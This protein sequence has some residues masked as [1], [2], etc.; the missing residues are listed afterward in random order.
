MRA[1]ARLLD[2]LS[3]TASR[4]A[5][6][7]LVLDFLAEQPDPDRVWALPALTGSLSFSA[8]KPAAIR[9]AVEFAEDDP[10]GAW[11]DLSAHNIQTGDCVVGIAASGTTPYVVGGLRDCQKK[12]ILTG[13]ITCNPK[14]PVVEVADYPVVVETGPE[15]VTGSTRMKA[16]TAQKLVLNM[17]S[18]TVMIQLGR[19]KGNRMVDMQIANNKLVHRGN[20][21]IAEALNISEE[22]A[23]ALLKEHGSVRKAI[24]HATGKQ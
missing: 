13:C 19:I 11:K 22:E 9:K 18:T 4:N 21:M 5:K 15:F 12:G 20:R 7:R 23:A 16:G 6:L 17:V 10:G 24:D 2:D 14:G 1:F 8:A 3:F